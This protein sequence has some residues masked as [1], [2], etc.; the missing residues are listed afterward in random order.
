MPILDHNFTSRS[1][2]LLFLRFIYFFQFLFGLLFPFFYLEFEFQFEFQFFFTYFF[3]TPITVTFW[4][5]SKFYCLQKAAA[6][7]LFMYVFSGFADLVQCGFHNT[8]IVLG[9]KNSIT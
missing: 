4:I 3:F 7:K 8:R 5:S 2:E 9:T 6:T 1:K